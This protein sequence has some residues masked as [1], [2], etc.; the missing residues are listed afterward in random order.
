MSWTIQIAIT[1][2]VADGK[3]LSSL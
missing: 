1:I 2:M 3:A